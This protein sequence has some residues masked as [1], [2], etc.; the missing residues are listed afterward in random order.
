MCSLLF[1]LRGDHVVAKV[2]DP[3]RLLPRHQAVGKLFDTA[4]A[5]HE[6]SMR[7]H[8]SDQFRCVTTLVKASRESQVHTA[9]RKGRITVKNATSKDANCRSNQNLLQPIHRVRSNCH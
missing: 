3:Y 1:L 2:T 8:L 5:E 9:R 4:M 7:R 6:A